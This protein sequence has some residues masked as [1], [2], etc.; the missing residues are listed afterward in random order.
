MAT[1]SL[2]L[3][4]EWLE[5]S[6]SSQ[7]NA[8]AIVLDMLDEWIEE[9]CGIK[10][11][12]ASRQEDLDGSDYE[13]RPTMLPLNSVTSV[14]D[15][16]STSTTQY[17]RQVGDHILRKTSSGLPLDSRWPGGPARFRVAYNGGYSSV[18]A[19]LKTAMLQLLHRAYNERGGLA[20][21]ASSGVQS[22]WQAITDS[23]I[24]QL[25]RPFRKVGIVR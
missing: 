18:P 9:Y 7:D 21:F 1:I 16:K 4:K 23:S 3:A 19:T 10:L 14:S 12:A 13:L 5:I 20:S 11:A 8:L 15:L 24:G 25:L 22:N 2:S 6:H 17:W